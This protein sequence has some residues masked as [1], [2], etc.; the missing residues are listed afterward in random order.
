MTT[1]HDR[2]FVAL[3]QFNGRLSAFTELVGS[4]P[5]DPPRLPKKALDELLAIAARARAAS[6]AI[7]RSFTLI[8]QTSLDIVD[9]QVRLQ[10]ETARLASALRELGEAVERQPVLR[11]A[12]SDQLVALDEAAQLVAAAVFPSAV[13]GLRSVNVKLWDFEKIQWKRYTDILSAVVQSRRIT[14]E[15]QVKIQ[16][17]ADDV[18]RAFGDVNTLLNELAESRAADGTALR[19]RLDA[20]A[21]EADDRPAEG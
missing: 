19:K 9:M 4:K 17:I 11:D 16:S 18:A 5:A 15:Q 2:V 8:E 12:F 10:G 3:A 21:R 6:D 20:G 7:T 1:F 14:S 13:Q